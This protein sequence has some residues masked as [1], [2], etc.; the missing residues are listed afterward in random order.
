MVESLPSKQ[1]VASSSLVSRSK[2]VSLATIQGY[3]I[4]NPWVKNQGFLLKDKLLR[5]KGD[6]MLTNF[7]EQLG[8]IVER[9]SQATQ[10]DNLIR[11]YRL[12]ART[13]GKSPKTIEI[14]T[15]AVIALRTFLEV[16]GFSTDVGEIGALELRE[17]IL[18]L[19]RVKTFEHHRFAK[20]QQKGLTGHTINCYLRAV[21]AFWSWLVREEIILSNPFARVRI[22]KPSKKVIPTFSFFR[23]SRNISVLI[24]AR[25]LRPKLS[26]AGSID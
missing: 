14:T 6:K 2:N 21:R 15:T 10:L 24:M 4:P 25:S 18:H 17:F 26:E 1:V 5:Q 16:R 9:K 8:Q 22:P 19:Q 23:V 13:E 7:E 20:P 3:L 12:Y 11:G